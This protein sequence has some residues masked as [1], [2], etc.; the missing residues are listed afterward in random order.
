MGDS[1][2]LGAG[3]Q[4]PG[5]LDDL[6]LYEGPLG[7]CL[8]SQ[9]VHISMWAPTAQQVGPLLLAFWLCYNL[10]SNTV[11]HISTNVANTHAVYHVSM[12]ALSLSGSRNTTTNRGVVRDVYHYHM[13]AFLCYLIGSGWLSSC[14][15]V[16]SFL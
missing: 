6:F 3:V 13:F 15:C 16:S 5:V 9:G 11:L 1:R 8:N 7:A 2:R 4:T 10:P 12:L 14:A